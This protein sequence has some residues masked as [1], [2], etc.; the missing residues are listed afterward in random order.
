MYENLGYDP[1]DESELQAFEDHPELFVVPKSS[2]LVLTMR[3]AAFLKPRLTIIG[4]DLSS[5]TSHTD[6]QQYMCAW[7]EEEVL[8]FSAQI[9]ARAH[10]THAPSDDKVL[11]AALNLDIDAAERELARLKHLR[12]SQLKLVHKG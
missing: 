6:L 7:L 1:Y 3:G 10:A 9:E 5:I 12:R 2:P 8:R 11:W 4:R